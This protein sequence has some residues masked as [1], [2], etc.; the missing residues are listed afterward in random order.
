MQL[1]AGL[2]FFPSRVEQRV[3][4]GALAGQEAEVDQRLTRGSVARIN[5]AVFSAQA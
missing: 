2:F 1:S 3:G 5:G 4:E